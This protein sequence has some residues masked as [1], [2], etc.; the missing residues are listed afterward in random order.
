MNSLD[1]IVSLFP[2]LIS[3]IAL[4]AGYIYQKYKERDA[5]IRKTRQEIHTR[6]ATNITG[7]G[8]IFERI[9]KTD[10]WKNSGLR[11]AL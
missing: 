3:A 7:R 10:A 1:K 8:A 2:A 4:L 5:V 6:M 11:G 9:Q